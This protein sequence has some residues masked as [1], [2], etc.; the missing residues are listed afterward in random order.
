MQRRRRIKM[1][2][3][4]LETTLAGR[5]VGSLTYWDVLAIEY[6]G[7]LAHELSALAPQKTNPKK[8]FTSRELREC[9]NKAI[10]KCGLAIEPEEEA[11]RVMAELLRQSHAR[12]DD[13]ST[14][15]ATKG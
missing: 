11:Q 8:P 5:P 13:S 7:A 2:K 14:G 6:K 15:A 9:E 1:K 4:L 3:S 12:P 10:E